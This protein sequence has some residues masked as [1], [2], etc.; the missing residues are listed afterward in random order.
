MSRDIFFQQQ[1]ETSELF[2]NTKHP[3]EWVES[4]IDVDSQAGRQYLGVT[5]SRRVRIIALSIILASLGGFFIRSAQLQLIQ[6]QGFFAIS[7]SNK[8]REYIIPAHRG[9]IF[10]RNGRRLVSNAANFAV[11][12]RPKEIANDDTERS[13]MLQKLSGKLE[14]EEDVIRKKISDADSAGSIALIKDHLSREEALLLIASFA[15]L[16]GIEIIPEEVRNYESGQVSS[17]SHILGYTGRISREE[18]EKNRDSYYL[19][20]TIGKEGIE[21]SY[22]NHLRGTFGKKQVEIDAL[23]NPHDTLAEI[24]ARDGSNLILTID[25]E[26]Q[27]KAEEFLSATLQSYE[28]KRGVM[29]VTDPRNGEIL[30]FVSLPSYDNNKFSSGISQKEYASLLQDR[31]QPLFP[32]ALRGDYP[33]GSTIKM[34]VAGAALAEGIITPS[35]TVVSSGG[36]RIGQWFFPDWKAGGHG[37][38]NVT[39]ALAESVNTFFYSIAGGYDSFRGLGVDKL[40]AYFQKFGIGSDTGVDLPSEARG[41]VPTPAWKLEKKGEPWYIGDT[42]HIAIGQGDVLVSPLQVNLYTSYFANGGKS[43]TPHFVKRIEQSASLENNISVIP[44][45]SIHDVLPEFAV[46]TVRMGLREAVLSGSARRLSLLSVSAAGKTGTA[47]WKTGSDP[48][49]WFTGW[50]PY[51]DPRLVVTVLIEEGE[52]GS[53]TA[54]Q[55][56]YDFLSWYY[57]TYAP[58][59]D[60]E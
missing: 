13:N 2:A 4:S 37:R 33:S 38:T 8:L 14:I 51:D 25:Y 56:A 9:T 11:Y 58:L 59:L 1:A 26:M 40:V 3:H 20:D 49:A 57:R 24:N 44:R 42:Y 35:T 47:Q 60:K 52:E 32:R 16:D 46:Q 43:Y 39:K 22:E 36:I 55:A 27:K 19:N 10:D 29:I 41:F 31:D 48:H 50:A 53:K 12:A 28:K 17:L 6:G 34:L 54:I 15:D 7:Q 23:S 5:I 45:L 21:L 18:F 30:T